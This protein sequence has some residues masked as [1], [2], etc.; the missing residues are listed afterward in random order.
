MEKIQCIVAT[1]DFSARANRAVQRAVRLAV[2]HGAELHL[3]HVLPIF[4]LETFKRLMVDTPLETEQ[5]LYNQINS[6]LQRLAEALARSGMIVRHHVAIGRAHVE[7]NRYA[8]SHHADLIV[9]GDQGENFA[10]EFFLGT[11]VS[12][13]LSK[14]QCP[15]L[16]VKQEPMDQYRHVLVPVDFSQAS[17]LALHMAL[18]VAP[19]TPIQVLHVVEMPFR[20]RTWWETELSEKTIESYRATMLNDTHHAME[21]IIADCAPSDTRVTSGIEHGY[22]P[23]VIRDK[24]QSL[25]ADLIVIGK[26]GETE[27]DE[28]LFGSITKHVLYETACDVLVVSPEKQS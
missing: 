21:E 2:E 12:K 15:L 5:M 24:A 7:I 8:E 16:I 26:R 6:T 1:T 11:T 10:Q 23:A 22:P 9:M 14:G 20:G 28:A 3:L 27:L 4:P 25:N 17:R 19:Q 18:K 13:T